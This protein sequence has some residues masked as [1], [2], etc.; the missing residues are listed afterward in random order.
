M[1]QNM[2]SHTCLWPQ[3]VCSHTWLRPQNMCSSVT[4]TAVQ[5][6][7]PEVVLP[8]LRW[9]TDCLHL[10]RQQCQICRL[11]FSISTVYPRVTRLR[12]VCILAASLCAESSASAQIL[13]KHEPLAHATRV[14]KCKVAVNRGISC[15]HALSQRMIWELRCCSTRAR[16]SMRRA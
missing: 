4:L 3:H 7:I 6:W 15:C 14:K 16:L 9:R 10:C 8:F 11:K 12:E 2:C 1:P 5:R 13:Q